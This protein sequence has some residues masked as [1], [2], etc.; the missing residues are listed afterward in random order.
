MEYYI[1]NYDTKIK[2]KNTFLE[3]CEYVLNSFN[4]LQGSIGHLWIKREDQ[5]E[6]RILVS[7]DVDEYMADKNKKI[8]EFSSLKNINNFLKDVGITMG[9]IPNKSLTLRYHF[10][11]DGEKPIVF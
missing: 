9:I 6:C 11:M 2:T 1:Y 7:N 4:G 10:E 8:M 5:K 3:C